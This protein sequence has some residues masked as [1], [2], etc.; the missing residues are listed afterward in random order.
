MLSR[1]KG[2]LFNLKTLLS[3]CGY[4]T[5]FNLHYLKLPSAQIHS[6]KSLTELS[7]GFT[8][9][10]PEHFHEVVKRKIARLNSCI[11]EKGLK[12]CSRYPEFAE[13]GI[14]VCPSGRLMMGIYSVYIEEWLEVKELKTS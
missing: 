6:E 12:N 2:G 1:G 7:L 13:A 3:A 11:S 4:T 9:P 10:S 8:G 5:T 14:F